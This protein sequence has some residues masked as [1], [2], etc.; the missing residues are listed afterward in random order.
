MNPFWLRLLLAEFMF[1]LLK[2]QYFFSLS[3]VVGICAKMRSMQVSPVL[4]FVL[5]L[6]CRNKDEPLKF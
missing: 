3:E 2:H 1:V 4:Y 6:Q 5:P